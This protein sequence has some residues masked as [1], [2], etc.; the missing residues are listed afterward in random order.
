MFCGLFDPAP[1]V[2]ATGEI[3]CTVIF[4]GNASAAPVPVDGVTTREP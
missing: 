2:C 3:V 1:L 4:A